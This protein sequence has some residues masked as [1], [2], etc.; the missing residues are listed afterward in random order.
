MKRVTIFVLVL[1]MALS[2]GGVIAA[3]AGQKNPGELRETLRDLDY[4]VYTM[5]SQCYKGETMAPDEG[6]T[7]YYSPEGYALASTYDSYFGSSD[8]FIFQ[9]ASGSPVTALIGVG[10][11]S[12]DG[13]TIAITDEDG[14]TAVF[15][16]AGR[17]ADRAEVD[18]LLQ[19][20]AYENGMDSV[21]VHTLVLQ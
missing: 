18:A 11:Y 20:L 6:T 10:S 13:D 16:P 15:A 5:V 1:V 14:W 3:A 4:E 19:S 7:L 2:L 21:L 9:F 8:T 12:I 17:S